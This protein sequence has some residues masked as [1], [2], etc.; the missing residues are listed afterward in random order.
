ARLSTFFSRAAPGLKETRRDSPRPRVSLA[1]NSCAFG[2]VYSL[3]AAEH[4]AEAAEHVAGLVREAADSAARAANQSVQ[5]PRDGLGQARLEEAEYG[6]HRP[7]RLLL[8]YPRALDHLF[9]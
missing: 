5:L 4:S 3:L 8:A 9:D 7:A 1:A 2:S 6:L